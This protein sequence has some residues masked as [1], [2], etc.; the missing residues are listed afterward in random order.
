MR[1]KTI[2]EN[3]WTDGK[4]LYYGEHG[5]YEVAD[6]KPF[7]LFPIKRPSSFHESRRS[8]RKSGLGSNIGHT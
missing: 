8:N 5:P 7:F 1:K 4:H 6:I 3:G 2:F